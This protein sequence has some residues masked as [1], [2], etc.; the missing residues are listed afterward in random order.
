[1][2]GDCPTCGA[3]GVDVTIHGDLEQKF[4][5]PNGHRWAESEVAELS[6]AEMELPE[7]PAEVRPGVFKGFLQKLLRI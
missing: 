1:M 6:P 4:L 5:C 2:T 7:L 3:H